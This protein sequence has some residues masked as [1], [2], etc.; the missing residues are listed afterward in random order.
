MT[1]TL[2]ELDRMFRVQDVPPDGNC[3]FSAVAF[4]M[5]RRK[6]KLTAQRWK[7]LAILLRKRSTAAL[8]DNGRAEIA[9]TGQTARQIL[10][11][12]L[13]PR[14]SI[15]AYCRRMRNSREWGDE[16]HIVA[17][18][19][20]LGRSM[21]VY[22]HTSGHMLLKLYYGKKRSSKDIPLLRI[23]GNHFCALVAR[24]AEEAG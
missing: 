9:G 6:N 18:A 4:T 7:R 14:R 8:C 24:S 17:L 23:N 21:V 13:G 11:H 12:Y 19:H 16:P 1:T 2:E 22:D 15:P 3:L 20:I 5:L 10:R